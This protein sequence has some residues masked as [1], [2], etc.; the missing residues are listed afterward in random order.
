MW[1]KF[2]PPGCPPD[3]AV[4]AL[5]EF[6]RLVN[7]RTI[8]ESDFATLMEEAAGGR[9]R[10]PP[11]VEMAAGCSIDSERSGAES[12][13]RA[14]GAMRT[15]LI[16]KGTISHSGQMMPTPSKLSP[17]HH[18]WWRPVGDVAWRSFEVSE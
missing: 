16:A 17:T 11:N 18:T 4:P 1:P 15:K 5:G 6:Y 9:R 14:F 7:N 10:L 3:A 8:D 12:V 13:Q 2:F